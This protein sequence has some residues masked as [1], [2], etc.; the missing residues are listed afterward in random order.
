MV[1]S[2]EMPHLWTHYGLEGVS[3]SIVETFYNIHKATF[4]G[5]L[6]LWSNNFCT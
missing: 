6:W 4:N 5:V 2:M 3:G 1:D